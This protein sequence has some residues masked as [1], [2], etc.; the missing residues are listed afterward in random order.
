MYDWVKFRMNSSVQLCER[1]CVSVLADVSADIRV[2]HFLLTGSLLGRN[3]LSHTV[4]VLGDDSH[5][6]VG[7]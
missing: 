3:R 1:S 2:I 7:S 6:V 4:G 5:Q